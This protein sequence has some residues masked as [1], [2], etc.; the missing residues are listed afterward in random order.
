M[1]SSYAYYM[2]DLEGKPVW[3]VTIPSMENGRHEIELDALTG[4][5]QHICFS[6]NGTRWYNVFVLHTLYEQWGQ[7][8]PPMMP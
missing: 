2:L 5:T 6:K 1:D 3:K 7:D 8:A 4:A